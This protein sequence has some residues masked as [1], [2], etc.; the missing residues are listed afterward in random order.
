MRF[1]I[2]V[3]RCRRLMPLSA[4]VGEKV[5]PSTENRPSI[6]MRVSPPPGKVG[7]CATK[8]RG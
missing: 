7:R 5:T 4:R 1:V 6:W 8:F 3:E 2:P